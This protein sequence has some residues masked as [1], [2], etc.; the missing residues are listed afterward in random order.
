M[1]SEELNMAEAREFA[2]RV[3]AREAVVGY[4]MTLDAPPAAERIARLGY[5]YVCFDAQH[6]LFG[7]AGMLHGLLAVQA[8]GA[9]V[10]LVRVGAND[11]YH[12]GRALD[13][14]ASG[15]IVPLVDSAEQAEA[16]VRATRYPPSGVRSYGPMRSGLRIGPTPAVSNES[17]VCL[18]MIE[19]RSGLEHVEEICRVPG[20]AGV[21]VGPSDLTL[22]IG[23]AAPGDPEVA[24]AFTAALAR[25]AAAAADAGVAAGVHTASG[26]Q[27][28]ERLAQGFTLAT[29]SSD[30]VHL[31]QAAA[32]HLGRVR[33]P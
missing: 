8:G 12:I 24:E 20:L 22:G 21:Y 23:G 32:A 31:E 27:A 26:E 13:A 17:V 10:G 33:T 1:S 5:D 18:A 25:V 29:V 11:P 19:T 14:G 3:R 30:V 4:W 16:A 6:G 7:Y 2:D 15:V 9:S 28:A